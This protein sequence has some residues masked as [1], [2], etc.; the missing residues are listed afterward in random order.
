[1]L[2]EQSLKEM[3]QAN[4]IYGEIIGKKSPQYSLC[5]YEIAKIKF[6]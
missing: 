4:E 6:L 3:L 5:L 1:M 2:Y